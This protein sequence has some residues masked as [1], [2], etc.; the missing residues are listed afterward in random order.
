MVFDASGARASRSGPNIGPSSAYV[1][2][3]LWT[4]APTRAEL[5]A[6][7]PSALKA[8]GAKG[9]AQLDCRADGEGRVSRCDVVAE[10]PEGR[11]VGRAAL[12]LVTRFRFEPPSEAGDARNV[13]VRV[14]VQFSPTLLQAA[15]PQ[16]ARPEWGRLPDAAEVTFPAKA[17]AAGLKAGE[18]VLSCEVQAGGTLRGCTVARETPAGMGFGE[19]ALRLAPSFAM[20]AWTSD[21]RPVDGARVRIPV[22]FEP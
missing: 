5:A 19:A 12:S 13:R 17:K 22:R 2:R 4:V 16:I 3:P 9:A 15:A 21:G 8:A 6:A 10:D 1:T 14:P 7:Y 18:A 20:T 11:G